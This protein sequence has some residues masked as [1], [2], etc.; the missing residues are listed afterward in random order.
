[1]WTATKPKPVKIAAFIYVRALSVLR[2]HLRLRATLETAG[3]INHDHVFS[4][5]TGAPF[6]SLQC[7][8]VRWRKT[9][10]SLKVRYRRP[11][12]ARQTSVSWN[13]MV[14]KNPLWVA[15]Q[16]G[17]S[18]AT[19]FPLEVDDCDLVNGKVSVT[20]VVVNGQPKNRTKT[21]Q[22]RE[23][24][25]CPRALQ[26]LHAQLSLRAQMAAA[27]MINHNCVF[28]TAVGEPFVN[29][30]LPY[31]RWTEVLETLP[32]RYRKPYNSRHSFISWRLMV[33]HNRL[34]VA[35]D[36]GHSEARGHRADQSCDGR[37]AVDR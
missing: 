33:G 25:L 13:L 35:Q 34:L 4:L 36:D 15:K 20:K 12:T 1:M 8:Q 16:H 37:Q 3:Q 5:E 17:H 27:G 10:R 28:F 2:Q 32:L 26:V 29:T 11:Y 7:P 21:N 30:S 31:R 23:I 19:V 14:G 18:I 22:D 6:R 24:H 9:F